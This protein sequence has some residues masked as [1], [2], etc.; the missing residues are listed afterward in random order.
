MKPFHPKLQLDNHMQSPKK[1]S[2]FNGI[3]CPPRKA[4]NISHA[5][6]TNFTLELVHHR[7]G[8]LSCPLDGTR[9]VRADRRPHSVNLYDPLPTL[10]NVQMVYST[11]PSKPS[12]L[13][14]ERC[15]GA[16]VRFD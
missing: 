13:P 15:V 2:K 9:A 3:L 1:S 14:I 16:P 12:P 11:V 10:I 4:G 8:S 5:R 6:V 7:P